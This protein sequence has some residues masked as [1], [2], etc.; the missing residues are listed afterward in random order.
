MV[1]ARENLPRVTYSMRLKPDL[2]KQLK[3]VAVDEEK[4][5]G[6]LVEEGISLVLEKR[7]HRK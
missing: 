2:L 6:E 7:K 1:K 5:V 4:T 3:H